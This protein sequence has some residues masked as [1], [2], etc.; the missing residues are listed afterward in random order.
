MRAL[1]DSETGRRPEGP[2]RLLT[3]LRYF[4]Y[5]I[6]PVS[7]YYC[8]GADGETLE[9]VV[10]EVTNTPWGEQDTYVMHCNGSCD[11]S[12]WR[13]SPKKKMH[14]ATVKN[15][16]ERPSTEARMRTGRLTWPRPRR[17]CC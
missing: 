7:F 1:V 5:V 14:V 17:A 11:R 12:V 4:G 13:F 2:V 8:F 16:A 6:N 9:T 10:A 3:H 15:R